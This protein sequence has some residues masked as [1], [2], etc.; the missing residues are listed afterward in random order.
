M[1]RLQE[2]PPVLHYREL[3]KHKILH[4]LFLLGT[5]FWLLG[6]LTQWKTDPIRFESGTLL[7]RFNFDLKSSEYSGQDMGTLQIRNLKST[8]L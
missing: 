6:L 2:K 1:S 5:D 7:Y 8:N 3:F 4:F